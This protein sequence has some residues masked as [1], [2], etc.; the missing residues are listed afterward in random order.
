VYQIKYE[1]LVANPRQIL[2]ELFQYMRMSFDPHVMDFTKH[3]TVQENPAWMG[4]V[5]PLHLKSLGRW[6]DKKYRGRIRQF[7]EDEEA[8]SLMSQLGYL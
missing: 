2:F 8:L 1:D 3:S 6:K 5:Q 4:K 7:E